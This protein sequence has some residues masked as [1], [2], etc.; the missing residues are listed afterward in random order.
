[1]VWAYCKS[2]T[3]YA[4]QKGDARYDS[5]MKCTSEVEYRRIIRKKG[6]VKLTGCLRKWAVLYA[7][8]SFVGE[9][10]AKCV[11][12]MASNRAFNSLIPL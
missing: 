4:S 8:I 1:M 5:I 7:W 12:E 6:C 3:H 9:I 10:A 11:Q 2:Q